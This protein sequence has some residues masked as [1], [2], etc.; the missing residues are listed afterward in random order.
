MVRNI[1]MIAMMEGDSLHHNFHVVCYPSA[2]MS[3]FPIRR[4]IKT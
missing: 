3:F 1:R 2:C 4:L